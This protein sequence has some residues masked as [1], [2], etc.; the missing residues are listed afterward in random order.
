MPQYELIC[1]VCPSEGAETRVVLDLW[2]EFMSKV[3]EQ[4]YRRYPNAT[5]CPKCGGVV[6]E[7]SSAEWRAQPRERIMCPELLLLRRRGKCGDIAVLVAGKLRA[8]G[9]NAVACTDPRQSDPAAGHALVLVDG[10]YQDP[11]A[12]LLGT[13]SD[14]D[15]E[16]A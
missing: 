14:C 8:E 4:F 9:R 3:A 13:E 2:L 15:C 1:E 5:C 7:P 6:Y 11:T 10:S 16:A 12:E